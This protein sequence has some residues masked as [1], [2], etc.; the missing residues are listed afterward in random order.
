[1]GARRRT[2]AALLIAGLGWCSSGGAAAP[3]YS[4][5]QGDAANTAAESIVVPDGFVRSAAA[6][7]SFG[8]WLRHLPLKAGGGVLLHDGRPV[9]DHGTVAAVVDIDVGRGDLQQCADA[10]MRLRA[11]YL[12]SRR[13]TGLIGFE[14]YS[15]ERYRFE[16]YAEGQT[17][18]PAGERIAWQSGPPQDKSH[19]SLRRWLDIVYSF[20]ST[21]SLAH[22]LR[23]VGRLADA[24]IGDVFVHPGTPGHAVIIV[25]LAVDSDGRNLVL[26]AQS[27]TPARDVHILRNTLAPGLG[28]WFPLVDGRPFTTP[29]RV[30][31]PDELKRF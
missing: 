30:F 25:D 3:A 19:A 8:E 4:W 21:R 29:G 7:G 1:M 6:P 23:P 27:S 14:L 31:T 20:A 16:A 28:P 2:L 11:E 18:V 9:A 24:A 10:V 22:E 15:G 26:L 5:L 12:F 13:L 17:P